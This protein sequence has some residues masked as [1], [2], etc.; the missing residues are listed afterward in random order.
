LLEEVVGHLIASLL[1]LDQ[2]AP[3]RI[4]SS[5]PSRSI[6]VAVGAGEREA[7]FSASNPA[8]AIRGIVDPSRAIM[9]ST[10]RLDARAR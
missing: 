4:A 3:R 7:A 2:V 6:G 10:S 8:P 1:V 5:V 9:V